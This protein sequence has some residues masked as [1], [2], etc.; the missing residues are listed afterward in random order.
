MKTANTTRRD[1]LRRS[2]IGAGSLLGA[3]VL[4]PRWSWARPALSLS[5]SIA[6]HPDFEDLRS[7]SETVEDVVL[8]G[9]IRLVLTEPGAPPESLA[10]EYVSSGY[11]E[12]FGV[13][14]LLGRTFVDGA[15]PL[16]HD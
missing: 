11:F 3:S 2:A 13:R 7:E 12:L 8:A 15:R 5:P 1:F 4:A 10:G 14:P 9:P 16:I 6:S